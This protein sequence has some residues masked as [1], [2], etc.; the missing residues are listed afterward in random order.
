LGSDELTIIAP[1]AAIFIVF[2]NIRLFYIDKQF[3][4][5]LPKFKTKH[6]EADEQ[7]QSEIAKQKPDKGQ[8][9]SFAN[10]MASYTSIRNEIKDMSKSNRTQIALDVITVGSVILVG[11]ANLDQSPLF[12]YLSV[13]FVISLAAG[14]FS[15]LSFFGKLHAVNFYKNKSIDLDN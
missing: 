13:L 6:D 12:E 2:I 1:I 8:V 11:F 7:L 5:L 10:L 9:L 3:D 14:F 15:G 4:E